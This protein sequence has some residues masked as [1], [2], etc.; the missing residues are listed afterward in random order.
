M[1]EIKAIR[2]AALVLVV[3]GAAVFVSCQQTPTDA[4]MS[5]LN[6]TDAFYV[7]GTCYKKLGGTQD[8]LTCKVYCETCDEWI[9]TTDTS[10]PNGYYSCYPAPPDYTTHEGHWVHAEAFTDVTPWGISGTAQMVNYGLR[11]DIDEY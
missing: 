5:A 11:L 9:Y 10:G 1:F 2:L 4:G 3:M 6:E 7:Y 8:G